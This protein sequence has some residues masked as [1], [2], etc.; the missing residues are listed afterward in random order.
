MKFAKELE[1]ELVPEWRIK[2]LNYKAG[3]KYVKA[4]S[5]AISRANATPT[6]DLPRRL[7]QG[8]FAPG[9]PFSPAKASKNAAPSGPDAD[10][11][12][13]ASLRDSP[14][15]LGRLRSTPK[16]TTQHASG[17]GRVQPGT[18]QAERH[19]L[20][21]PIPERS[22][23]YGS[24]MASA[25]FRSPSVA[26]DSSRLFELPAPAIRVPSHTNGNAP[27][28]SS[29]AETSATAA[30][31]VSTV[32]ATGA[33]TATPPGPWMPNI[34]RRSLSMAAGSQLSGTL[35]LPSRAPT[36]PSLYELTP[37]QRLRRLFS[38]ATPA[39]WGA[40]DTNK[41]DIGLRAL[42][43]VRERELDFFRLLDSELEKVE[44]FYKLKEEQA[45]ERLKMLREQL[46]E[47]RNRRVVEIRASKKHSRF[48]PFGDG[49]RTPVS[50]GNNNGKPSVIAGD[51]LAEPHSNE[52]DSWIGPIR[53]KLFRPGPNSK[54]LQAMAQT[55]RM[56]GG[57][58]S[59]AAAPDERRDYTRRA[60]DDDIPYRT[61]KH[62]LKLALQEFYRGLELLKSYAILNRT[63]FRKLNKKYDKAVGAR[64]PYRYMNERVNRSW[65][66]NSS[67]VDDL[68]VAVE[69][70]YARYFERGNHKIAAGKLRALTRRPGDE[71][72]SAFRS[73]LLI[74]VGSVFSIQGT[75][76]GARLLR[77]ADPVVHQ[78]TSYLLQIYGGYFLM[79]YLF[80]LFCLNGRI[81][82]MNKI[83]Y[84]FIF[85]FD[86]RSHIDWRQLSQFPSFFLLLFGLFFWLNFSVHANPDLF[87]Y[88]PV[89][90]I[91]ITL[92][93]LF[94]P[95]P[96][97][98]HRSR[99]WFL[100]S[101]VREPFLPVLSTTDTLQWRLFFAGLYPVEFRDFFLGDMYCSLTYA[102]CNVELFFCIYAHEWD[103]P[104]QCNSS[105]SRLLG[106]FSTLP[107]IWRALQCIRRYHDTKNVFPHLVNCGKYVMTI[108]SYVFLSMY[109]ISGTNANL[110]LFIVFSVI[111][112]LYTSIWDLFMDF[113]LLQAESRYF[114]LRDITALKHRW[115]YYVIMFIDP[116]L[117]FS[118]IFYA[119]FTHDSQHN[120][121]VSFMVSFA[122][123]TRRGMWALLRVENEH[124]G[125][126]AQYKASRDVPLPYHLHVTSAR[127]SHEFMGVA[128]DED[129][130]SIGR[131]TAVEE[132]PSIQPTRKDSVHVSKQQQQQQGV[133]G[134]PGSGAGPWA[135]YGSNVEEGA[136]G[137]PGTA[138]DGSMAGGTTLRRRRTSTTAT[139]KK[140]IAAIMAEAHMQDFQKKRQ[141]EAPPAVGPLPRQMHEASSDDGAEDDD[142]SDSSDSDG[143]IGM[144]LAGV[145]DGDDMDSERGGGGSGGRKRSTTDAS[146]KDV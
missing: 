82:T 146:R 25:R 117:R 132:T 48:S 26:T 125:N 49:S 141:P 54:A 68:I 115:V 130:V 39:Q 1:Q 123:V 11:E 100:Y 69:D 24:F 45:G 145:A 89:I 104:S 8:F 87:L 90:L 20:T 31:T 9:S 17:S 35:P 131:S 27:D 16:Q 83:N 103:D 53:A 30:A 63:A 91:G 21:G 75:V 80:S 137:R 56:S 108:L 94:L 99:K 7:S 74:G 107:S 134:T 67:V 70:L 33:V 102:T 76:S 92:V 144:V 111:N 19:G 52:H 79:L 15:P 110:S 140:T 112:G 106:F 32:A 109:R 124:C 77:D 101:H 50:K 65:F 96:T 38:A 118:W 95:L 12:G 119:I 18:N 81:W 114:L 57:M 13:V 71:S 88:Y 98:W 43:E 86:P 133:A 142:D 34:Q 128:D 127:L 61:A 36:F 14:A 28:E 47:M 22:Q 4:V 85:E 116:I 78:Q 138:A 42:D 5:R 60:P 136:A 59:P 64:P 97:L 113:S 121:I 23:H 126:V 51:A 129:E 122:E 73:G 55:P 58:V 120:T 66:V 2:Y 3:K 72:A 46:H 40:D 41:N 29:G 135:D 139:G 37:R 10:E 62:K 44:S 93:F 143:G 105:R 84:S 6:G